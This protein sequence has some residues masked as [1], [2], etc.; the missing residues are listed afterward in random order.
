M[1]T[2]DNNLNQNNRNSFSNSAREFVLEAAKWAKFLSIVGFVMLGLMVLVIFF[3]MFVGASIGAAAPVG[4]G[5]LTYV[6]AVILYFFPTYYLYQFSTN[7]KSGLERDNT[8]QVDLGLENLK[9]TF[10][11]IGISTIVVLSLYVGILLFS[12]LAFL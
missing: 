10:K 12:L 3:L 2:L 5:I 6:I 11:F 4:T 1:E 9:S 7:I 8:H